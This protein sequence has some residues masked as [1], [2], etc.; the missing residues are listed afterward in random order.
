MLILV[1]P[2]RHSYHGVAFINSFPVVLQAPTV[3]QYVWVEQWMEVCHTL[4]L[5]LPNN[6]FNAVYSNP[7]S[8]HKNKPSLF[9]ISVLCP[10][11]FPSLWVFLAA[12]CFY[13]YHANTRF[14]VSIVVLNTPPAPQHI[15]LQFLL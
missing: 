2:N 1:N 14:C 7:A 9:T 15:F 11:S 10:V 12:L 13:Y 3:I 6:E 4:F 8:Y 5:S